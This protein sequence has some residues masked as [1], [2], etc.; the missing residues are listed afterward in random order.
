MS[1]GTRS[2]RNRLL[3]ALPA[4]EFHWLKAQLQHIDCEREQVLMEAHNSL[5]HVFFPETGIVSVAAVYSDGS[6]IEMASLGREGCTGPQA[7]L[8]A[9]FS[10]A[11]L[12][13]QIAGQAAK[14]SRAAFDEAIGSMPNFRRLVFAHAH[15]FLEQVM[16]SAACNRAHDLNQRLARWLLTLRDRSDGDVLPVTQKLLAEVLG[17]QRPTITNAAQELELTGLI[18]RGRRQL[19]I[20]DRKGLTKASCECYRLIRTRI[21]FH[22]PK[23]YL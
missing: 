16:V 9:K 18:A 11:R 20:L 14:M 13:V 23:T 3:V 8:G 1:A 5:D 10:S 7:V 2:V 12:R 6:V 19:T 4:R 15:A 17:V 21:A 22:L